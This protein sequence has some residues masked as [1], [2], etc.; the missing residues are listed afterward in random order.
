MKPRI[1]IS[2]DDTK[3]IFKYLTSHQES[4]NSIYETRTLSFLKELH[5]TYGVEFILYC[6]FQDGNFA[7]TQVPEKYRNQFLEAKDWLHF[8]YHAFEETL[9]D[10][11]VTGQEITDAYQKMQQEI[12][13]ITGNENLAEV[14][15]LHRFA[16][17]KAVCRALHELGVKAFLTADDERD[18][19]YLT[20]DKKEK[21]EQ[22]GCYMDEEEQLTFYPSLTRL[23]HCE[24]ILGEIEK[25]CERK[26]EYIAVFT[27]EWQMDREEIRRKLEICC[28]ICQEIE[29]ENGR[30]NNE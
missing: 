5:E 20:Q 19:Y 29:M 30:N 2:L 9:H 17:G 4:C 16:G 15:R 11:A 7:L 28:C 18:S 26:W 12:M 27:H 8:G 1:Q 10:V 23:E 24:D 3:G 14:V 25:A 21:L 13:R 22:T 6:V